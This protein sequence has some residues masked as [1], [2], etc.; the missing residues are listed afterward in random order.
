M[1]KAG[2]IG[3]PTTMLE[4]IPYDCHSSVLPLVYGRPRSAYDNKEHWLP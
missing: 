2:A 1:A 3:M 4:L